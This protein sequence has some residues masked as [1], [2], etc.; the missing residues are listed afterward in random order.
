MNEHVADFLAR[1]DRCDEVPIERERDNRIV[2]VVEIRPKKERIGRRYAYL[3]G[4]FGIT[5]RSRGDDVPHLQDGEFLEAAEA[6]VEEHS[7][8]SE[9]RVAG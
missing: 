5:N 8:Q 7:G 9:A 3:S 1:L 6:V 2:G 4:A